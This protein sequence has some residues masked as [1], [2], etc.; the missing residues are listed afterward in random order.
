M[1]ADSRIC[2]APTTAG[3]PCK[4]PSGWGLDRQSGP[5]R[6]H[7][8]EE[9]I[10]EVAASESAL[11]TSESDDDKGSGQGS[12]G[13]SQTA[14]P[15]MVTAANLLMVAG[16]VLLVAGIAVRYFDRPELGW[17]WPE[18]G[19]SNQL[20]VSIASESERWPFR[21][22]G[23]GPTPNSMSFNLTDYPQQELIEVQFVTFVQPLEPNAEGSVR[24]LFPT[25]ADVKVLNAPGEYLIEEEEYTLVIIDLRAEDMLA[26]P[27]AVI[28]I[29]SSWHAPRTDVSFGVDRT[30]FVHSP[31]HPALLAE[32]SD[33]VPF[34]TLA[35]D[36][37]VGLSVYLTDGRLSDARPT[38]SDQF[39]TSV[40]WTLDGGSQRMLVDI[41]DSEKRFAAG[42]AADLSFLGAG[43]LISA[44]VLSLGRRSADVP[45]CRG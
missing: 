30:G 7:R 11:L 8:S 4:R 1:S 40:G 9:D 5:C 45:P 14:K 31:T 39:P 35:P 10:N 28:H 27:W 17:P 26:D 33:P 6:D 41:E 15:A 22:L 24:L 13:T 20:G 44:A 25:P 38:T 18:D 23:S 3:H 32:N 12:P 29:K 43:A 34:T 19:T 21:H 42:V 16:L 37:G 36:L 2:G